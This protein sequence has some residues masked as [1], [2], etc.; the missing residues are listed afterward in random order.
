MQAEELP[1]GALVEFQVNFHTGRPVGE[2]VDE[3]DLEGEYVSGSTRSGISWEI[4]SASIKGQGARAMVY[5]HGKSPFKASG[6]ATDVTSDREASSSSDFTDL[7]NMYSDAISV[8]AYHTRST[9]MKESMSYPHV[10][11]RG[12]HG[13][14][15]SIAP[16]VPYRFG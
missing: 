4:C 14:I 7:Q 1:K 9:E 8:K 11:C 2:E 6:I 10:T 3:D 5:V 16:H 13:L 15:Y 12:G